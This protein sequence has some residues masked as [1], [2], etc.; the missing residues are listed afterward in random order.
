MPARR[1][2]ACAGKPG[3]QRNSSGVLRN[4]KKKNPPCLQELIPTLVLLLPCPA[5]L[6]QSL[7]HWLLL[8]F[9]NPALGLPSAQADQDFDAVSLSVLVWKFRLDESWK[10][11]RGSMAPHRLGSQES[12]EPRGSIVG[13]GWVNIFIRSRQSHPQLLWGHHG[14]REGDGH[15]SIP[16]GA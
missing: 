11:G 16:G 7:L 10:I 2:P 4:S 12:A 15:S 6:Q 5:A 8:S 13:P 9:N 1:E 3:I 14:V